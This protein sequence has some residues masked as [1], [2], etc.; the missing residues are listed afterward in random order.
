MSDEQYTFFRTASPDR[1]L[2]LKGFAR[3]NRAYPT[4][5][6]TCLWNVLKGMN[7]G[8]RFRRQYIIGDYIVDFV[9]LEHRIVLEVDGAYHTERKQIE[10]D[11]IRTEALGR[12]GFRVIRFTNE[13]VM[14]DTVSVFTKIKNALKY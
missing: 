6:E 12:M 1:Y 13:E 9:C 2:P 3:Q 14:F 11:D 4:E 7:L 10:D 8:V 5:A